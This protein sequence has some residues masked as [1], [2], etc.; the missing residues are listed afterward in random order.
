MCDAHNN[1]WIMIELFVSLIIGETKILL[2]SKF[3]IGN[4]VLWR[5]TKV[6]EGSWGAIA[7]CW[8]LALQ[9][10][11]IMENQIEVECIFSLLGFWQGYANANLEPKT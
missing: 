3:A 9:I 8:S 2:F 10:L 6:V 1:K 7:C 4:K 5:S 11:G